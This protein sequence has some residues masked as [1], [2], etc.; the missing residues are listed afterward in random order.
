MMPT[1]C[2]T[3]YLTTSTGYPYTYH[4]GVA[5]FH[6]PEMS[7]SA[8]YHWPSRSVPGSPVMLTHQPPPIY[9]QPAYH[10][11][12]VRADCPGPSHHHH[13]SSADQPDPRSVCVLSAM[14]SM[15]IGV[16]KTA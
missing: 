12:Q 1:P 8:P 6:T 14:M 2:G 9:Q 15:T 4:N 3:M 7:P 10:H 11:Y 13:Y 5:Y 16:G